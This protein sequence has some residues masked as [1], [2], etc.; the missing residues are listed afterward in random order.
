MSIQRLPT[1]WARTNSNGGN[2]RPTITVEPGPCCVVAV[3]HVSASTDAVGPLLVRL[4]ADEEVIQ[5]W[6]VGA[7]S[8]L[9][10]HFVPAIDIPDGAE[11]KLDME[12]AGAGKFGVVNLVGNTEQT[13]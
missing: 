5:A 2:G 3:S 4:M 8:P 7:V 11:V 1:R 13:A 12:A 6:Y 10:A 9:D